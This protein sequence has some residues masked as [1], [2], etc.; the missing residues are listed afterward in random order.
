MQV[1]W[2]ARNMRNIVNCVDAFIHES[3]KYSSTAIIKI[4]RWF[5]N[6][7]IKKAD[8]SVGP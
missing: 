6:G 4:A 1:A 7:K 2:I 5:V 8:I 3:H